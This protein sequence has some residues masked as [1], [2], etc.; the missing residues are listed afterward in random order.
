MTARIVIAGESQCNVFAEVCLVADYIAQNLPNFCFER[1]E[2]AVI[3][4]EQ[5]LCKINQKNKWHHIGSPIVWKELLMKG[6][7]PYYIG[8]ASDFLDYC[9]SYYQFDLF[10]STEKFE[11]LVHN[12]SQYEKKLKTDQDVISRRISNAEFVERPPKNNFIVT[13]SCTGFPLA[14]HL[15]SGLLD[16]T[17]GEKSISKIY[18]YDS[19]CSEAFMEFVERECSF[20]G[21]NHP[22]KVVK[23]VEK[24]GMALTHTDLF[25]IL[26]H[27]PLDNDS[28]LGDWLYANKQI[29]EDLALVIN[30]SACRKMY[31]LF[32]NL[33][34][35]CYNATVLMNSITNIYKKNIVVATSD[36]GLDISALAAEIAEVPMRNMFCPP[37]WG[38]VGINQLVD[39]KTTVHKYNSFEPYTRY[40]KVKN[41][42]LIIGCLTPEM[43]TLE[44]LMHF[45][46]SLWIKVAEQKNKLLEGQIH[47]NK[48]T[49]VLNVVKL[50]LFDTDPQNITSLGIL[51][52]GSFGLQFKGAFSQPARLVNGVWTP[53][54]DYLLPKDPQIKLP[55]LEDMAKYVMDL[56]KGDLPKVIPFYPCCC[57]P[58]FFKKKQVW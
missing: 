48:A 9:H 58:K 7:K 26:D 38:F 56:K 36:L 32:P 57:K 14:M 37:V 47:L 33:G 1:I 53:A 27:A 22:G 40:T 42:S 29:M 35:A 50:W 54:S 39:I 28:S 43:R 4:W 11:G 16:M 51:C 3:E 10:L 55:Y 34:P 13:I 44:Y 41:S 12:F 23:V 20:I 2:K 8:G 15:V 19:E 5:W 21:T 30:A 25:I 49:A 45:D 6:S 17:V 31:V 46:E 24:V 52:D 18:I